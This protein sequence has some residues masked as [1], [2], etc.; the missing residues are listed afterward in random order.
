[1]DEC[2]TALTAGSR[3]CRVRWSG[4]GRRNDDANPRHLISMVP[5][6]I[7]VAPISGRW[8][9]GQADVKFDESSDDHQGCRG[10]WGQNTFK[11][12]AV[13]CSAAR[14][15]GYGNGTIRVSPEMIPW[16][17]ILGL[18]HSRDDRNRR[19][20]LPLKGE[21]N[22]DSKVGHVPRCGGFC[23]TRQNVGAGGRVSSM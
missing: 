6:E 17:L 9:G 18:K 14:P 1:M 4:W 7:I 13:A 19:P 12:P 22:N 21:S 23:V 5:R 11:K 3:F 16:E 15:C 10:P 8:D 20:W 2:K